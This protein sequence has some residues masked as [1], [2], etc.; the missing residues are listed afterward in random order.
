MEDPQCHL[1]N[2][3]LL[4]LEM[5]ALRYMEEMVTRIYQAN[6]N[7]VWCHRETK[8]LLRIIL[9]LQWWMRGNRSWNSYQLQALGK[10]LVPAREISTKSLSKTLN[11]SNT[12]RN[13]EIMWSKIEPWWKMML[14]AEKLINMGKI[15]TIRWLNNK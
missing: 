14:L 12:D 2:K 9:N 1:R 3:A 7:Q 11:I 4:S 8:V 15:W 5:L 10:D 13:L 6:L